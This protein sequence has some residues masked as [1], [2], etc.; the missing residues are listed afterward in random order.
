M[1]EG[2]IYHMTSKKLKI[3]NAW[4]STGPFCEGYENQVAQELAERKVP[5]SRNCL[6]CDEL[7]INYDGYGLCCV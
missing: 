3:I 1:A 7:M 4:V 2:L 5:Q 6:W